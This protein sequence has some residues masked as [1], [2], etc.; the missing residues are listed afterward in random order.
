MVFTQ[1]SV[2]GV[3]NLAILN[4]MAALNAETANR[5][6][7]VVAITMDI[8]DDELV[9]LDRSGVRGVRLNTDNKGGMPIEMSA[10]Q[11]P[12]PGSLRSAGTSSSSFPAK[13]S[14]S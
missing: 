12:P 11:I 2:Y 1:P 5:A 8:S 9:A 10:I 4:G 7:A 14:S 3:D 6:R 13:T